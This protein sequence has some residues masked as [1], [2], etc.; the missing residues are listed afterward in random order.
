M[1]TVTWN[2]RF[3][4]VALDLALI[5]L[6]AAAPPAP[7]PLL[8]TAQP[9][10]TIGQASR[11]PFPAPRLSQPPKIL[12]KSIVG[13]ESSAGA[14]PSPDDVP[15]E[16]TWQGP[17]GAE[18]RKSVIWCDFSGCASAT[19]AALCHDD[20]DGVDEQPRNGSGPRA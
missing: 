2:S 7:L 8:Q 9:I 4:C 6:V 13:P 20:D 14:D 11:P 15:P 10:I 12:R 1:V 3:T 18:T 19:A 17:R 5:L 16:R